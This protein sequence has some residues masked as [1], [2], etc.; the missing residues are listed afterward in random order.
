MTRRPTGW[1]TT[2]Q[3]SDRW[4]VPP[5]F[6]GATGA[7]SIVFLFHHK[8]EAS[9]ITLHLVASSSSFL[10]PLYRSSLLLFLCLSCCCQLVNHRSSCGQQASLASSDLTIH[11]EILVYWATI[12]PT[13]KPH[14]HKRFPFMDSSTFTLL[15]CLVS[16]NSV[17]TPPH[18]MHAKLLRRVCL[19]IFCFI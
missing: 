7:V 13:T 18:V 15:P 8:P 3:P 5:R 16:I 11:D 4:T 14:A 17:T 2:H 1:R 10:P 9:L 19:H 12:P 6:T